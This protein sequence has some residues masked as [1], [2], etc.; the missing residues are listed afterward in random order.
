MNLQKHF[1]VNIRTEKH[2]DAAVQSQKAV[3]AY[4]LSKKLLPFGF[5]ARNSS[6]CVYC[7]ASGVLRE[8]SFVFS[9]EK[10]THW[11]HDVVATLIDVDSTSQL[12][13]VPCGWEPASAVR[14][15][16]PRRRFI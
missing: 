14:V 10:D 1:S 16:N 12:R 15:A 4:F 8:L 13:H 9:R 5:E 7:S 2:C 6:L 11:V 3:A